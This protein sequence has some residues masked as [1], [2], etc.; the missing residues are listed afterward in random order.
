[1]KQII[2][3]LAI[4]LMITSCKK[5]KTISPPPPVPAEKKLMHYNS[6]E[7][8]DGNTTFTYDAQ[9]RETSMETMSN[10]YTYTY[11]PNSMHVEY[12]FKSVN[13]VV[14]KT[15]YVINSEG[16][17][18][19]AIVQ[20]VS[21]PNN[22]ITTNETFEYDAT[23]HLTSWKYTYGPVP[24][25]H[26]IKQTWMNDNMVEWTHLREGLQL[27][28]YTYAYSNIPDKM[29]MDLYNAVGFS[30]GQYGKKSKNLR[31]S[32]QA[33]NTN[34][35]LFGSA[36]YAFDL[37]GEGFPVKVVYHNNTNNTE[38]HNFFVYNK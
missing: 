12:F 32:I 21:N 2:F 26:E 24:E 9:G 25:H 13:K 33:Y 20:D 37:D 36:T 23:G 35:V 19:S 27:N 10:L 1:M 34:N 11:G 4:V 15:D 31:E 3:L 29:N 17:A 8:P 22:V 5:D 6:Q 14:E 38:S 7:Y 28:R 16:Y 18:V 30:M